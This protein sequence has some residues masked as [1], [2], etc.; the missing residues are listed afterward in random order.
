MCTFLTQDKYS[1]FLVFIVNV[2]CLIGFLI[3]YC[4]KTCTGDWY[5]YHCND[6]DWLFYT[7]VGVYALNTL[8]TA[9]FLRYESWG[10]LCSV[11][12]VFSKPS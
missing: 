6:L 8:M 1:H 10:G 7:C 11:F 12:G 5:R 9:L 2:G 3:S 4:T